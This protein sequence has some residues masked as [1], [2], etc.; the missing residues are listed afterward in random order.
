MLNVSGKAPTMRNADYILI[1]VGGQVRL[2]GFYQLAHVEVV[3]HI[4]AHF[5][6]KAVDKVLGRYPVSGFALEPAAD[7]VGERSTRGT[8]AV[9]ALVDF[10]DN[11]LGYACHQLDNAAPRLMANEITGKLKSLKVCFSV[12]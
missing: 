1:G 12:P 10:L 6:I 4:L 5:T 9:C 7:P 8:G 11:L 2:V 3:I